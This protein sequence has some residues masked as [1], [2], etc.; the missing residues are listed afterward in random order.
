MH[1]PQPLALVKHFG[2]REMPWFWQCH[3]DL[4]SPDEAVWNYLRGFVESYSAAVFSLPEY[5][6]QLTTDQRIIARI[7]HAGDRLRLRARSD[8]A[9]K[10]ALVERC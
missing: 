8:C 7:K 5:A 10:V 4:S 2:E 3:V 9:N 1:D 6:Q